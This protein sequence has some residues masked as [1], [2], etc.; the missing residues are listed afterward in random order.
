ML[1]NLNKVGLALILSLIISLSSNLSA[2]EPQI[3]SGYYYVPPCQLVDWQDLTPEQR[4]IAQNVGFDR[5]AFT[6]SLLLSTTPKKWADE[7]L[8]T[9]LIDYNPQK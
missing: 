5:T 3:P 4:K 6:Q 8:N 7:C 1:S 2:I 9:P